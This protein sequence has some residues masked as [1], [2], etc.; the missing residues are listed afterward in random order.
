MNNKKGQDATI[1]KATGLTPQQEQASIMLASGSS[2]ADVANKLGINRKTLY[3]W[4]RLPTFECFYNMQCKD[5]QDE[6][7]N[8]LLGLHKQAIDT[9]T[10]LIDSSN[11]VTR[12]KASIWVLDKIASLNIGSTDVRAVLKEQCTDKEFG[13]ESIDEVGY[14]KKLKMYRLSEDI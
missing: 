2:L 12:L 11:E 9:I 14:R 3:Q 6:V 8:G 5:Y 1:N 7:K 4:Q 13:F 10:K